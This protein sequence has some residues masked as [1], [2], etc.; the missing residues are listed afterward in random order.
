[1]AC[2]DEE[3]LVDYLEGRLSEKDRFSVEKHLSDCDECLEAVVITKNLMKDA[4]RVEL[5]EVPSH[6]TESA[7]DMVTGRP[8]KSQRTV[9]GRLGRS[10]KKS[11]SWV[12]EAFQMGPWGTME[13]VL[14][15]GSKTSTTQDL[16][17]LSVRLKGIKAQ[18]EIERTGDEKAHI[19]VR[20]HD[21]DKHQKAL[22][23]TL[24]K[25]EREI[26]SYILEADYV[27][28][29]DIPSGEYTIFLTKN[30]IEM[31]GCVFRVSAP[32]S[33]K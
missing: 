21:P 10:I 2:P 7:V 9:I 17:Q 14:V 16:V 11:F 24:I 18:I 29:E 22:R 12:S 20:P 26:A 25:G 6:V 32:A 1:M 23:V 33:M 28:F 13:P 19:R 5:T 3:R 8:M 4:D 27:L 15:R 31:G 30:G